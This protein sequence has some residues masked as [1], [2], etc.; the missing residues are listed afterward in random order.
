MSQEQPLD[1][2]VLNKLDELYLTIDTLTEQELDKIV[3]YIEDQRLIV[4]VLERRKSALTNELRI[5]RIKMRKELNN[6]KSEFKK[7]LLDTKKKKVEIE[8]EESIED[9]QA[10][11][12]KKSTK[13]K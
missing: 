1:N 3:K 12:V 2:L 11:V 13:K 8:S 6:M 4:N 7:S 10:R 5:E 9:D